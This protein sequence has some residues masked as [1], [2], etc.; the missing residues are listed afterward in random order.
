MEVFNSTGKPPNNLCKR[1]EDRFG[2]DWN[3]GL[4]ITY[5]DT[6]YCKSKL[7]PDLMVH[8][9]THVR[10]QTEMGKDTWWEKYFT[11]DKFRLEQEVE[12]YQNQWNYIKENYNRHSRKTLYKHIID[13]MVKMY[14]NM[15]T[16]EEAINLIK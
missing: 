16:E 11:D 5:G 8:E 9:S 14:G 13:S 7:T 15:C 1:C 10:Q 3:K 2:V 12:A 6:I 4:I